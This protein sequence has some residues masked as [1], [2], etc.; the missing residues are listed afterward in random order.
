MKLRGSQP[1]IQLPLR[2]QAEQKQ[3]RGIC[4]L[5]LSPGQMGRIII[6]PTSELFSVQDASIW[7]FS[8]LWELHF[9]ITTQSPQPWI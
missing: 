5:K 7:L 8:A 3:H 2:D 9:S 4:C 1:Q 6:T